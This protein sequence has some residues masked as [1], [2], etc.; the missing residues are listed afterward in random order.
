MKRLTSFLL[1][2]VLLF[3][4]VFT[5]YAETSEENSQDKNPIID[6]VYGGGGKGETPILN[7]FIELYNPTAENIDLSD[8]TL[9][10]EG[11]TV[12]LNGTIPANG[13]FLVVG[14]A[15]STTDEFLTYDLPRADQTCDWTISNKNYTIKLMKGETE[16]DSVTAGSTAATKI[17][18]QKSLKRNNHEDF[19]LVVWEKTSVTVDEAYVKANAPHNSKGEYGNVHT[20]SKEPTYTPVVTG[21]TRVEGF[22]NS[23]NSIKLELSGRYNS[24]ALNADGGSLEIVS[25][26]SVTGYAY[27]VSGIKGKLIAVDLNRNDESDKVTNL[28]G[29]EYDVKNL[30]NGFNY[31]DITSVA[32]SPDGSRLAVAIQAENYADNGVAALFS[33]AEDGSITFL[34]ATVVGIQPDMITFADNNTILTADE[35]EPREGVNGV[36]PKGSVTVVTVGADNELSAKSVYF[37]SFD[38]KRSELVDS[39]VL[40]QKDTQPS[41][42]FEP[43][44]IAVS[45]KTAYVSLQEA[46][47]VAVLDIDSG[48]F[49]G[50][51][52]LGY[53][54]YGTTKVDLQ[55]NDSIE[56]ENYNNVYGI[57]MPDGISVTSINGKT[58]L[59]TANEGDSR[60]DWAGLDNEYENVTS[61][62]GNVTLNKKVVWFNANMWDG[63]DSDKAYVFGG[64]SFSIY[65]ATDSGLT[66][67][68]DSGS[69]FEEVTA[70][71]LPEYFNTSNDKT[72]VDNRSGKKGPE[73]ESVVTG[74]VGDRNYAFIALERIGG[75]M[76]YDITDPINAKF[77]NY[78]NSR[79]FDEAIKGDV[80]PEGLCFIPASG[81]KSGKAMLLAACEVSGTLA[82]YECSAHT[83]TVKVI[84]AKAA[85][86]TET[87]LTEG[88][89]CSVCNEVIVAQTVVKAKGHKAV[90]IEAKDATCTEA[91]LTEGEICSVCNK[92]LVAQEEISALGHKYTSTITK[93]VTCTEKGKKVFTC[94]A[95][96]DSYTEEI[97]P[98]GHK[99]TSA[100]TKEATCTEKGEKVFTCSKCGDK[101]TKEIAALG[102]KSVVDKAVSATCTKTGL[103]E[104]KHCSVCNEVLVAQTVVKV[105]EHK[106][107]LKNVK[108]AT[109]FEKG[110]SGDKYC[111]VCKKII[112][113]GKALP[114]LILK[115]PKITVK[116]SKS[117]LKVTYQKASGAT[118]YQVKYKIGKNTYIKTYKSAQSASKVY[119]KLKAGTYKMYVRAFA[120][121]SGKTAYS[122]WSKV[123]KI[124]VK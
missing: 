6:Q 75:I 47:A 23:D 102:H 90:A 97:E 27:A 85:T 120:K 106:T 33:C 4:M 9:E 83:H 62:T 82:A 51:Y 14:S 5:A 19:A 38:L 30:V 26:N 28:N 42:D 39:G 46:N 36:D 68:Y 53:Q 43:E 117:Q 111:T 113:K 22:F 29:V 56:L 52:P 110:Y 64:R 86:C 79:E 1:A 98:T 96:G 112:S 44:Y 7:S 49:S 94:T 71:K 87:G 74:I 31:G 59:L 67:V 61:P 104:G 40:I 15:E 103:S 114:K 109:Y 20:V 78:I 65:E 57:K 58:Y 69:G 70:E 12:A 21:D 73:P 115:A 16:V 8:Y 66:L 72:S 77:V 119:K 107:V 35:G 37:D 92:I 10:Y 41:T 54:D 93:E 122:A 13:S 121:K 25:Y 123:K 100:T 45:G 34:S 101:Y 116:A 3:S 89:Y 24:G 105:K 18:K 55:K 88:K 80:S 63:L 95:C 11:K 50:V 99:Y 118:G 32:V 108:K 60:A 76:V 124:K 91:G 81:S 84:A 48:V 17:S 2:F